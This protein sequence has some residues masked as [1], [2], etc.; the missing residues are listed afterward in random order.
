MQQLTSVIMEDQVK[1]D[2][3]ISSREELHRNLLGIVQAEGVRLAFT[4]TKLKLPNT[5]RYAIDVYAP[6]SGYYIGTWGTVTELA[7]NE[8]SVQPD[9]NFSLDGFDNYL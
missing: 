7:E 6:F 4:L 9:D 1:Q 3:T 5:N 2:V 8:Y